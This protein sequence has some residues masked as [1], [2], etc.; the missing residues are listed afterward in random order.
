MLEFVPAI[1]SI[2]IVFLH[3][4]ALL[5]FYFNLVFRC[6]PRDNQVPILLQLPY[7]TTLP[8]EKRYKI[9]AYVE[10]IF[11][12]RRTPGQ[13]LSSLFQSNGKELVVLLDY[14]CH[15]IVFILSQCSLYHGHSYLSAF[16][17]FMPR[18]YSHFYRVHLSC[19]HNHLL[20]RV[21]ATP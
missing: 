14:C 1:C 6:I 19:S 13:T 7:S 3:N 15:V 2:S 17:S 12:G 11:E 8:L 18:K 9:E 21:R 10:S 4:M 20:Y 16:Q 5:L